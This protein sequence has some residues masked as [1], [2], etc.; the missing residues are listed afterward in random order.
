MNFR[1]LLFVFGIMTV[2]LGVMM[3]PCGLM[4]LADGQDEWHVFIASA[5]FAMVAGG[6][7]MLLARS[8]DQSLHQRE[9]FLLTVGLWVMMPAVAAIPFVFSGL[10]FTDAMFKSISG[11]TT[12]GATVITSLQDQPRGLLLWRS[13]LTW[14]GGAGFILTAIL[15]LPELRVGGMQLFRLENTD[16]SGKF[17][18]SLYQ[19][20]VRILA[21]YLILSAICTILYMLCGMNWFDAINHMMTTMSCGGFSTY[22]ASFGQ[23]TNTPAPWV[24]CIFMLLAAMP[25]SLFAILFFQGRLRPIFKDPQPRLLWALAA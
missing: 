21:A 7:I 9:S 12:T 11:L 24:A 16:Q 18:S 10:S 20:G 25:F 8:G 13:L 17:A 5:F 3:V 15:L 23:F 2:L 4:D 6:C 1:P 14:F 19:I 22:D